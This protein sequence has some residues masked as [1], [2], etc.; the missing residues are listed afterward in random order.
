[1]I[2]INKYIF[3]LIGVI[4]ISLSLTFMILYLN[5]LTIGFNFFEYLVFI[6]KRL[7]CLLIIPGIISL[8]VSYKSKC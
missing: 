4:L 3:F 6:F 2:I 8:L 1:V 7:E 5:L